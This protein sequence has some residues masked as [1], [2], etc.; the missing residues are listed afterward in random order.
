MK[1]SVSYAHPEKPAWM[2][3][4]VDEGCTLRAAIERSGILARYEDIDLERNKVGIFGK[5]KPLETVLAEGDRVEIYQ[6]IV[7]DPKTAPRR[8]R[9]GA[10]GGDGTEGAE[11]PEGD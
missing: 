11:R 10:D 2:R 4:D 6:P 9:T 3:L 8:K 7:I 1:I 5:I